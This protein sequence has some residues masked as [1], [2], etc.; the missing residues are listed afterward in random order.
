MN[1]RPLYSLA[2]A[3]ITMMLS[4]LTDLIP[5]L[6]RESCLRLPFHTSQH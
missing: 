2:V 6:S 5:F 1:V 4:M 3:F